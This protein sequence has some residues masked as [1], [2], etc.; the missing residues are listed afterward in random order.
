MGYHVAYE[1]LLIHFKTR[2]INWKNVSLYPTDL[3]GNKIDFKNP[4]DYKAE[5][6]IVASKYD[7]LQLVK[8]LK[9]IIS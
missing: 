3:S 7:H 5:D 9:K 1:K 6:G 4:F 8:A 2:I